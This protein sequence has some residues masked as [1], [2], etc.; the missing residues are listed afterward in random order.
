VEGLLLEKAAAQDRAEF[1]LR[2]GA[3]DEDLN[4]CMTQRNIGDQDGDDSMYR[5]VGHVE[6]RVGNQ[7]LDKHVGPSEL[8][9]GELQNLSHLL[10]H[11]DS[12]YILG[13]TLRLASC[14]HRSY[15]ISCKKGR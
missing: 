12:V 13:R 11:L 7:K 9:S 3:L 8:C 4:A 6:V 5:R 1:S 2:S 15:S 14:I 10:N